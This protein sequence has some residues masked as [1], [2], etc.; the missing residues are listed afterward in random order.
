MAYLTVYYI[1]CYGHLRLLKNDPLNFSL[2]GLRAAPMNLIAVTGASGYIGKHLV[3]ELVR[4]G[5]YRVRVLSRS[6]RQDVGFGSEVEIFEGDLCSSDSLQGFLEPDCTVVNLVYLWNAGEVAN[7]A[8]TNNLLEA[9]RTANVRRLIHCSTAAVVG[10]VTGN[11]VTE[12]TPCRPVTEYGIT[13]LKVESAIL[14]AGRGNLDVAALRPTAVFGP[15]GE[16]L[17]KLASDLLAGNRLRNYLKSSL[18]GKRRMNLVH[19]ANVVGA[20]LF[21]IDRAESLAG[22]IFIVSDDDSSANNFAEVE[23]ALMRGLNI[24]DYGLPRLLMPLSLLAFILA[25]LGRNN[26]NPLCNY[27]PGKLS[28]MGFVRPVNF[29]TG[30]AEYV[31]WYRSSRLKK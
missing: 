6:R 8:A 25:R 1:S 10:R 18:F 30:L 21:L 28:E 20:I 27:D 13:K 26:I 5:G 24:R 16:P 4:S 2:Q 17:K 19:I 23:S 11:L 31:T 15:G 9:C 22:E 3:A 12:K 7:L 29:E 14:A